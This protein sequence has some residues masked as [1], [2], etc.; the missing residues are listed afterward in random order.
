MAKYKLTEN[1]VLDQETGAS[2]PNDAGNRHWQEYQVWLT[3]GS[4]LNTPDS[5]DVPDWD[6]EGRGLRNSKL[7][8]TDWTQTTDAPLDTGSPTKRQEFAT[9]RQALRDLPATYPDYSA[10]VWPTEPTYP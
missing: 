8:A 7:M 3:Q 6:S 5:A 1:G 9:Y 10:V 4:P 2:I